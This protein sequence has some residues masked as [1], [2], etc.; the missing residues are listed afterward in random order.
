VTMINMRQM[1]VEHLDQIEAELNR[2]GVTV[3]RLTIVARDSRN[4]QMTLMLSSEPSNDEILKAFQLALGAPEIKIG[5]KELV[6]QVLNGS[7][8][9]S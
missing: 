9:Q 3:N 1:V 5:I 2:M 6:D 8:E 7:K 4:D